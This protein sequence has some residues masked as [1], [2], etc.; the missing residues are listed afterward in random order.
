MDSQRSV[1]DKQTEIL[2]RLKGI[3]ANE[4]DV[5]ARNYEETHRKILDLEITE[6]S[7]RESINKR[8]ARIEDLDSS[9]K[10]AT[11]NDKEAIQLS[12]EVEVCKEIALAAE[13]IYESAIEQVRSKLERAVSQN[14]D[15]VKLG[16]FQ[17]V[18][19]DDFEVLTLKDGRKTSLSEGEKMLKGYIF[20]IA[21]RDVINLNLPLV[22]DTPFGRLGAGFRKMVAEELASLMSG[23]EDKNNRQLIFSMHD[24]EY[25]PLE[26]RYFEKANPKE[27]YLAND[28]ESPT[29]KSILGEGIDPSWYLEGH[30]REFANAKKTKQ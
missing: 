14:F 1:R 3:N 2:E 8:V 27:L 26:R 23:G 10:S 24:L 30:W 13:K 25:T 20:S 18:I 12:R 4:V 17:T 11:K 15:K 29:E 16:G 21:L 28:P 5:I 19:T 7:L 6:T 22:V 9:I